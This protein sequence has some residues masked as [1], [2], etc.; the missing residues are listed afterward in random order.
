MRNRRRETDYK[1]GQADMCAVMRRRIGQE[2]EDAGMKQ[3]E[4]VKRID[5]GGTTS[6]GANRYRDS[7]SDATKSLNNRS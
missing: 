5:G 6:A 3:I 7:G 1:E 4:E 2:K